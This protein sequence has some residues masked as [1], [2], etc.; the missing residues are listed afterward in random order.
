MDDIQASY[1]TDTIRVRVDLN[2]R[3]L[4]GL[5]GITNV[6]NFGRYQELR[7]ENGFDTQVVLTH[8]MER[9]RVHHFELARPS[10]HDIFIRIAGPESMSETTEKE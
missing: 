4:D 2:G 8:L 10:L 9:G 3:N 6:S 7:V 1:A 5:P